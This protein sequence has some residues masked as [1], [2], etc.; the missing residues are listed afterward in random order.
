MKY[1]YFLLSI[2]LFACATGKNKENSTMENLT[3]E[4]EIIKNQMPTTDG[5]SSNY[6]IVT[7]HANGDTLQK[8]WKLTEFILM[9]EDKEVL[10]KLTDKEINSSYAGKGELRQNLS[11]RNLTGDMTMNVIVRVKFITESKDEF[12]FETDP[13]QPM[14]VE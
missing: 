4:V 13:F 7:L 9:K 12:I 8:N 10:Q 14:V 3:A 11:V 5:K 2:T 6:A 1:I